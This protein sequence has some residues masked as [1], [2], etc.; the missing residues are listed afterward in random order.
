MLELIGCDCQIL[1]RDNRREPAAGLESA[2]AFEPDVHSTLGV[3]HIEKRGGGCEF[4]NAVNE[5]AHG[6]GARDCVIN[7]EADRVGSGKKNGYVNSNATKNAVAVVGVSDQID[8]SVVAGRRP[9]LT[10]N[11]A[12][13]ALEGRVSRLQARHVFSPVTENPRFGFR[14]VDTIH[15]DCHS[16]GSVL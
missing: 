14:S 12:H 10:S 4:Q 3:G 6:G 9:A 11:C 13:L 15:R 8:Q 16:R 2:V 7:L 5:C 1:E